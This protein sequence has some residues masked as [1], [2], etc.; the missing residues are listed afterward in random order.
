MS[1]TAG[2]RGRPR[3]C[4]A[5]QRPGAG[6]GGQENPQHRGK[7]VKEGAGRRTKR[8]TQLKAAARGDQPH[9]AGGWTGAGHQKRRL[10][11]TSKDTTELGRECGQVF[12]DAS[13]VS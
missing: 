12:C 4:W 6:L 2:E 11:S 3:A 8:Q 9:R 10:S 13:L 7:E 1:L 5:E